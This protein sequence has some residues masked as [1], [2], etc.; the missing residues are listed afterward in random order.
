MSYLLNEKI[1]V[2][3]FG[4]EYEMEAGGLTPLEASKLAEYVDD[5]MREISDKLR[6]VD[7]QK[8]AVLACLNVAFELGQ[9]P[10]HDTQLTTPN[11]QKI[12]GM[13]DRL[14]KALAEPAPRPVKELNLTSN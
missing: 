8:I 13:I 9:R 14:E 12:K 11:E 5:K 7:T 2:K 3:I 4:R 6:I 1:R 10:R